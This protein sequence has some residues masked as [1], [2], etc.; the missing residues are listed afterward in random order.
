MLPTVKRPN[1]RSRHE[2]GPQSRFK[3][4]CIVQDPRGLLRGEAD[5]VSGKWGRL[6]G[7]VSWRPVAGRPPI[8]GRRWRPW[9][10]SNDHPR[11]R[12]LAVYLAL[13]RVDQ[14]APEQA[15]RPRGRH[16]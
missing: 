6:N 13:F 1:M 10:P 11:P 2:K 4:G 9:E 14:P 8:E 15:G 16:D 7:E 5:S 3:V 12:D